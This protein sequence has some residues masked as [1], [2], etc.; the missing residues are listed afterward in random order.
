MLLLMPVTKFCT[1]FTAISR[2]LGNSVSATPKIRLTN[3]SIVAS[4]LGTI[5]SAN[6]KILSTKF[7]IRLSKLALSSAIPVNRFCHADFIAL[8]DPDMVT[9][10][11]RAVVPNRDCASF[12]VSVPSFIFFIA[13]S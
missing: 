7:P 13:S 11:S 10:A 4:I 6:V 12:V 2:T 5:L 3:P 1:K 8:A 9:L